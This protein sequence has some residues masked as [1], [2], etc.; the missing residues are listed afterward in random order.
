MSW[1]PND[2]IRKGH[3][4]DAQ[5]T[6]TVAHVLDM[7][8][9][10][11]PEHLH[12]RLAVL[13]LDGLGVGETEE[14]RRELGFAL[15][16][17]APEL[18]RTLEVPPLTG[19]PRFFGASKAAGLWSDVPLA[20]NIAS[21]LEIDRDIT[22]AV[23]A[24]LEPL[25][26]NSPE[27]RAAISRVV[28]SF[29]EDPFRP[30]K[31]GAED[32]CEAI[33]VATLTTRMVDHIATLA[34][35][36]MAGAI[37][38]AALGEA[39]TWWL[40]PLEGRFASKAFRAW[41]AAIWL[42]VVVPQREA[43]DGAKSADSIDVVCEDG[44]RHVKIARPAASGL[45]W[46]IGAHTNVVQVDGDR[47]TPTP[48]SIHTHRTAGIVLG[49]RPAQRVLGLEI[50]REEGAF[51]A[52]LRDAHLLLNG[53]AGKAALYMLGTAWSPHVNRLKL[54]LWDLTK[55]L[56][57]NASRVRKRDMDNTAL[58]VHRLRGLQLVIEE[59]N[60][61]HTTAPLLHIRGPRSEADIKRDTPISWSLAPELMTDFSE[62]NRGWRGGALMNLDAIL[63]MPA[64]ETI[65]MRLYVA[66]ASTWND[67][68][69]GID[70]PIRTLDQWTL[71]TNTSPN[72]IVDLTKEH[73]RNVREN[74]ARALHYL[75]SE[76]VA[77]AYI[78][79]QR[80]TADAIGR[81]RKGKA[82]KRTL[83]LESEVQLRPT[84][85]HE[86]AY[87]KADAQSKVAK[88]SAP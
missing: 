28:N 6:A 81:H 65:A 35:A 80:A 57:K 23:E 59:V 17:H 60:G 7:L 87:A 84:P 27:R 68:K 72:Q 53:V 82:F 47:F 14:N 31:Y 1:D 62:R 61:A 4:T 69:G 8:C 5:A 19:L 2:Q 45:H 43:S 20:D 13:A 77:I 32:A 18:R 74:T 22:P 67:Q 88:P 29:F 66:A 58:A 9:T 38:A 10:V 24:A 56:H 26:E 54:S 16:E 15:C 55:E 71:H 12:W 78:D 52:T 46:S 33:N 51:L 85:Q 21:L 41:A 42:G 63:R 30:P 76:G 11:D 36:E 83:S 64:S 34:G 79:G 86:A 48:R 44:D 50:I 49:G 75:V 25:E 73:R 40:L 70:S 37:R 3:F 39:W